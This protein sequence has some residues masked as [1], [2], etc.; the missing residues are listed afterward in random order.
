[1][2]KSE[3]KPIPGL[4]LTEAIPILL[5][6]RGVSPYRVEVDTDG[7][8]KQAT[9]H[10]ICTG[11]TK[12]PKRPVVEKIANYFGLNFSQIYDLDFIRQLVSRGFIKDNDPSELGQ[13]RQQ[14]G[15]KLLELNLEDFEHLEY[16]IDSL[17]ERKNK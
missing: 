3:Y 5:E 13:R 1:M 4:P 15:A 11:E 6:W 7:K 14:A 12:N 10:R 9:V 2:Y 16:L 8:I 17:F